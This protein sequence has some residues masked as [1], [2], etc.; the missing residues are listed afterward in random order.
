MTDDQFNQMVERLEGEA[1]KNPYGYRLRV[2]LL[3]ALGYAYI[4]FV[5]VI[6]LILTAL[7]GAMI[8]TGKGLLLFKLAVPVF[9]SLFVIIRALWVRIP[10][11]EGIKLSLRQ[12]GP[13]FHEVDQFR[14]K[15]KGPKIHAIL[16]TDFLSKIYSDFV[17]NWLVILKLLM[18]IWCANRSSTSRKSR[19]MLWGWLYARNGIT[20]VPRK[21]TDYTLSA[22]LTRLSSS[23]RLLSLWSTRVP[24]SSRRSWLRFPDRKYT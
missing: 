10:R 22:S 9:A 3:A 14:R 18:L 23:E 13:L 20:A 6:I 8:I 2:A 21:K 5:L 7:L 24:K 1:R 4:L 12:A 11:P 16:L 19:S 17:S 15:V